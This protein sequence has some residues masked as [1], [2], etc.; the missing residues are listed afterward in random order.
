MSHYDTA[1]PKLAQL[2]RDL[3]HKFERNIALS[4]SD[5]IPEVVSAEV[6]ARATYQ[7][8]Q[9]LAKKH[10]SS[11]FH[12]LL[13]SVIGE[14]FSDT[15]LSMYLASC[16]L[17]NSARMLGRRALE[18]GLAVVYLWDQPSRFYGWYLHDQDLSFQEMVDYVND[19]SFRTFLDREAGT[20][21][22]FDVTVATKLYRSFSN[23]VHGKP[24]S[25]ESSLPDRFT[26]SQDDWRRY[27]VLVNEAQDFLLRLWEARFPMEFAEMKKSLP[28]LDGIA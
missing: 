25:L 18:M 20:K 14:V 3:H 4:T 2:F 17:D 15:F 8:S 6:K 9:E 22:A 23:V 12:M 28:A 27:I 21:A 10:T 7:L 11:P 24:D 5:L 26:Y 19:S 13:V 16:A 1:A